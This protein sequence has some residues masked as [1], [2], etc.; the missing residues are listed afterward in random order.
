MRV[1]A[2]W[3]CRRM[4][5]STSSRPGSAPRETG[6]NYNNPLATV[7]GY[8]R[9]VSTYLRNERRWGSIGAAAPVNP[10]ARQ[11]L[12]PLV[13]PH[14]HRRPTR[15]ALSCSLGANLP[16][17][18]Q[19][20]FHPRRHPTLGG[21]YQLHGCHFHRRNQALVGAMVG[22]MASNLPSRKT[23]QASTNTRLTS[24]NASKL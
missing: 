17:F 14:P 20:G 8:L 18:R 4:Q 21:T 5:E 3:K 15:S 13:R 12:V 9:S 24:Y 22:A 23:S 2:S 6:D 19:R 16:P 7:P 10:V 1:G 11:P